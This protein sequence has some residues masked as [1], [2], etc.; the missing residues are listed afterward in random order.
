MTTSDDLQ[1]PDA[2]A[3]LYPVVG[4]FRIT[5]RDGPWSFGVD[6]CFPAMQLL[7]SC[8]IWSYTAA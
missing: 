4:E 3:E 1:R 6:V 5:G 2:L 8:R 7:H